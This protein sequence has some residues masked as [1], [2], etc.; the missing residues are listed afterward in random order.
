MKH[1][2]SRREFLEQLSRF[3]TCLFLTAN[4][5][6]ISGCE[7][8]SREAFKSIGKPKY[9]R[10]ILLGMDGMD[11]KVL[12]QLMKSGD[13][14]NFSRLGMYGTYSSLSTS[15]PAQSPSAW[16]SIATGNNPGYHGIFDFLNRRV[17][18]YMPELA[19]F[20]RNPRNLLGKREAMFLPVMQGDRFWDHTSSQN[21][22]STIIRWPVTFQPKQSRAKLFAGLGV[23]DLTGRLGKYSFYTSRDISK[24]EDGYEKVIRVKIL[25]NAIRTYIPGPKAVSLKGKEKVKADMRITILQEDSK[26]MIEIDNKQLPVAKGEWSDWFQVE[27]DMGHLKTVTGIVKFY[28]LKVRPELELYMTAVQVNP[29]DPAFVITNPDSY[30]R[31]LSKEL[32]YFHTLGIPEDT[33]ALTEGRI[34]EDAFIAMCDEIVNEQERMLN[35]E[36]KRF[37]EG[38]LSFCFFTTDRIQHIFWVTRDKE[39]PRYDNAYAEKYGQVIND[40]Y[41]R[42]DRIVGEV[43]GQLDDKTALMVFSDHGF[44]TYRRSIHLNSWLAHNGFMAL[45]RRVDPDDKEGGALFKYVDWENTRAYALGFGGIY[46]NLKGREKYG[47]V[48]EGAAAN[49]VMTVLISKLQ[50]LKDPKDGKTTIKR[51]YRGSEIYSGQHASSSPDLIVGCQEGYRV[52]WQS[53][54]GGT[55][56]LIFE[57]NLKK[58]T[59][60][61]IMDPSLVPGILLTNFKITSDS[62]NLKDIAPSVL[63]CFGI[64]ASDMDGKSL[65]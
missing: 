18:D 57:D 49:S 15:N 6:H 13:M 44:T 26:I 62:P 47:I 3:G 28:L 38:L 37:K 29:E 60:D 54:I 7:S 48:E 42:M 50:T 31:E 9:K 41:R 10:V 1:I 61:H 24:D 30:I 65:L 40:Y 22:S 46:L 21:I 56:A 55:P 27:F 11:P 36:L 23:P 32:G 43:T 2:Y 5:V 14:P 34:G 39:H 51:V 59:G 20:K 16:A 19:I 63:S 33:K 45:N 12:S 25:N 8:K 35:Y 58:W 64:A 53:A 4:G 17:T 52:S